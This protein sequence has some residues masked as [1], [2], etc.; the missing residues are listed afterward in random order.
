MELDCT[1][2]M[3]DVELNIKYKI[4]F[5]NNNSGNEY[6]SELNAEDRTEAYSKARKS[7]MS[8]YNI[9]SIREFESLWETEKVEKHISFKNKPW[10]NKNQLLS[11]LNSIN[12]IQN[13]HPLPQSIHNYGPPQIFV[14]Y[15]KNESEKLIKSR[16]KSYFKGLIVESNSRNN[17]IIITIN[18]HEFTK[19]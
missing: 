15:N 14:S 9:S 19:N 18:P 6:I 1:N 8:K 17:N 13:V 5:K 16:I 12:G 2:Y 10:N 11:D 7:I 3:N 4:I